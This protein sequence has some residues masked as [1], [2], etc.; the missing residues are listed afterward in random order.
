M[1]KLISLLKQDEDTNSFAEYFEKEYCPIINQWCLAYRM[2]SD[3]HTN[4]HLESF[5]RVL[6]HVYIKGKRNK[7][8]DKLLFLLLKLR[9]LRGLRNYIREKGIP[10][11]LDQ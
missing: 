11:G 5:H 3:V 4:M 9:V 1:P 10:V 6:K 7:R 8:L 2:D